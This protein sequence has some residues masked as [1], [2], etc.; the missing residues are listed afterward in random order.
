MNDRIKEIHSKGFDISTPKSAPMEGNT[1]PEVD[2]VKVG[3]KHLDDAVINLGS[4]K[5]INPNMTKE[6]IQRAIA[7]GDVEFMREASDFYFK[8]SGI[9]SR[10]CKHLA[11]FYRYDWLITPFMK[12]N[13]ASKNSEQVIGAFDTTLEYLVIGR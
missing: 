5:K 13:K 11:N 6:N 9:Y 2:F 4:Y 10:L 1:I 12:N 8:I 3:I 7:R